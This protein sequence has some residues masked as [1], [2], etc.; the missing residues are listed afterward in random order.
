MNKNEIR[1]FIN[2]TKIILYTGI[3]ILK[4]FWV[5]GA[6][7]YLAIH[8]GMSPQMA[9]T[10]FACE[11]RRVQRKGDLL[12]TSFETVMSHCGNTLATPVYFW[13]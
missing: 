8:T 4:R 12:E 7:R 6:W 5:D 1:Y 11:V 13:R 2:I 3:E 10:F 9:Q